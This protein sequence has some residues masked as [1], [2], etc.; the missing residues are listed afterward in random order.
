M[1]PP[2]LKLG[3]I[4]VKNGWLRAE[5]LESALE[6]QI[7]KRD[8]LGQILLRDRMISEEQLA[9]ALSEQSDIAFMRA[10]DFSIDWDL[11]MCFT[12]LLILDRHCFPVRKEWHEITFA[13]TNTSDV[14]TR[15]QIE[16]EA[17]G[18]KIKLVL[19]TQSDMNDLL[20]RYRDYVKINMRRQLEQG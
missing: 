14:W 9:R 3:E 15:S 8:F 7:Q 5:A 19:V 12:A 10:T 2:T 1:S 13:V 20:N 18:F 4:L 11:V 6:R 16:T 17:R